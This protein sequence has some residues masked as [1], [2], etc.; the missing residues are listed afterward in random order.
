MQD[1]ILSELKMV[2]FKNHDQAEFEFSP[3]LNALVGSNGSGKTTVL[4]AIHVLCMTRS[5]FYHV[6]SHNIQFDA[7]F[8][9]LEGTFQS[10]EG[11]THVYCGLKRGERKVFKADDSEYQKFSEHLGRF[12]VV[13][14][15]PS[16]RNLLTDGAEARRKFVDQ[17]IAQSNKDYLNAL[18]KYTKALAQRNALLKYFAANRTFDP[19][20]LRL[21]DDQMAESAPIIHDARRRFV[22]EFVPLLQQNYEWISNGSEPVDLHYRSA[23][24]ELDM[25]SALEAALDK[26]RVMQHTTVGPHRDDFKF[27]LHG[28]PL[29]RVGSQGQQKSYLVALK[30]ATFDAL[31]KTIGGKPILLL[32]DVFDKLDASRV[33]GLIRLVNEHHFGQIFISDTHRERTEHLVKAVNEE[34]K[35]FELGE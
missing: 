35:V 15:S 26:D 21:Y 17:V 27:L 9:V 10:K 34:A 1:V 19:E 24:N 30:L 11:D 23:L 29:V 18:I 3:K 31:T 20:M 8:F 6:D 4:D 13:M 22:E 33:E 2:Q 14:I 5:Y 25:R 16:D 12:P 7:P 28:Y 32:D